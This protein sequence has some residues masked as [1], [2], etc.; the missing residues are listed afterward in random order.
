[1]KA[2]DLDTRDERLQACVELNLILGLQACVE[3]NL[4]KRIDGC[5]KLFKNLEQV[6][7]EYPDV[8][9]G[10]G[11][12]PKTH[13]IILKEDAIPHVQVAKRVP[14]ALYSRLKN[15]LKDLEQQGIIQKIDKPT[16]WLHPLVIVEK[17]NKDLRLCLNPK[18]LI[19]IDQQSA[20]YCTFGT[21][22]GRNLT[23]QD[24]EFIWTTEHDNA[25]KQVKHLLTNAPVLSFFN[26]TEQIEIETDASKDG[27]GACLLQNVD[28][29][30]KL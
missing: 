18:Y 24:V 5:S 9:A 6:V 8:F 22:F 17:P 20:D 1:M 7:L 30:T 29:S 27:L 10:L 2:T 13:T 12:Y 21:P 14:Q 28:E 4:I 25:L 23:R 15:K 26:P 16:D 11:Q 3:L 19:R